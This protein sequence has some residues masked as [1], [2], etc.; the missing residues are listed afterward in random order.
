MAS[1]TPVTPENSPAITYSDVDMNDASAQDIYDPSAPA[2]VYGVWLENSGS[3]ADVELQ[4]TDGSSTVDLT[5][6]QGGGSDLRFTDT[7]TLSKGDKLRINVDTAEG[8][9]QTDTAAI[10]RVER[11]V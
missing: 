5:N 8:S 10:A 7:V 6:L 4:V 11:D 3:T 1:G 2:T 9:S